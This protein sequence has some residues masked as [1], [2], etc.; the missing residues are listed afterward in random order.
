MVS[1]KQIAEIEG[2]I[3]QMELK[4]LIALRKGLDERVTALRDVERDKFI[5]SIKAQAEQLDLN[6]ADLAP[7]LGIQTVL[8]AMRRVSA[9]SDTKERASPKVKYSDGKGNSWSG[10]GLQPKWITA[11]IAEGRAKNKED[12]LI[13]E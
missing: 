3:E 13:K 5:A 12:F 1:K 10:R 8:R 2:V 4:E 6:L 11:A 9:G 7:Q